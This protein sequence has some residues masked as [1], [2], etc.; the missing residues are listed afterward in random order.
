M[1][2]LME[3]MQTTQMRRATLG[4]IGVRPPTRTDPARQHIDL[5]DRDPIARWCRQFGATPF[6][7]SSAVGRV[8]S[9]AT[10]VQKV[11]R[12]R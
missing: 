9:N 2:I 1:S 11:L 5:R 4:P 6:G 8:G 7:P 10:A 3:M 12:M